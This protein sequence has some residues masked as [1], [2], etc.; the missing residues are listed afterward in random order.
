V[1]SAVAQGYGG[2]VQ[3]CNLKCLVI[4]AYWR[5][6]FAC[7][8]TYGNFNTFSNKSQQKNGQKAPF[9]AILSVSEGYPPNDQ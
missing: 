1:A 5:F 3:I 6:M 7:W 2:Q 9:W 4:S 8:Q